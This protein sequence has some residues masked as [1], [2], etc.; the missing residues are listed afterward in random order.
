MNDFNATLNIKENFYPIK[1]K[2]DKIQIKYQ[3]N[4]I[5]YIFYKPNLYHYY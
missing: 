1:L 2:K 5:N 3:I 4:K